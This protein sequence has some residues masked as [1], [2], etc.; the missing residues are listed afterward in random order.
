MKKRKRKRRSSGRYPWD[1]KRKKVAK[2]VV[3]S[4]EDY[5]TPKKNILDYLSENISPKNSLN[6]HGI[7]VATAAISKTPK[8]T[9]LHKYLI[10]TPKNKKDDNI[11]TDNKE[12]EKK[13]NINSNLE[14]IPSNNEG[15]SSPKRKK[16]AAAVSGSDFVVGCILSN[17][18][19]VKPPDNHNKHNKTVVNHQTSNKTLTCSNQA[20]KSSNEVSKNPFSNPVSSSPISFQTLNTA[21]DNN[22]TTNSSTN[23]FGSCSPPFENNGLL[24][25]QLEVGKMWETKRDRQNIPSSFSDAGRSFKSARHKSLTSSMFAYRDLP[26]RDADDNDASSSSSCSSNAEVSDDDL[27]SS[28]EFE[29]SEIES[30]DE[31]SPAVDPRDREVDSETFQRPVVLG[32]S[33]GGLKKEKFTPADD[34]AE[35]KLVP[36]LKINI[37]K[38]Q[39][40]Q[41][42]QVNKKKRG[43]PRKNPVSDPP[44]E[45]GDPSVVH[46]KKRGRK[47]KVI[48]EEIEVCDQTH[49]SI[50][51]APHGN[52]NESI[53]ESQV[54]DIPEEGFISQQDEDKQM[55]E[56]QDNPS[57]IDIPENDN[58]SYLEED[59]CL[60]IETLEKNDPNIES[61]LLEVAYVE[62]N[63]IVKMNAEVDDEQ[64]ENN[65]PSDDNNAK[66]NIP[67]VQENGMLLLICKIVYS[68]SL[69]L[70]VIP[71]QN[72]AK[73]SS[74]AS[75]P[76]AEFNNDAA[77]VESDAEAELDAANAWVEEKCRDE[78]EL[79]K[80]QTNLPQGK[81]N[82]F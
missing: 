54:L 72:I 77:R 60:S 53:P 79:E 47:K 65:I 6:N 62:N 40:V 43:R 3:K 19:H 13:E 24:N 57:I 33:F 18:G 14:S 7:V 70:V 21:F 76:P 1:P 26:R 41:N 66:S 37:N 46:R 55:E 69:I 67:L 2:K 68:D 10:K 61:N 52:H 28:S 58:D 73:S 82:Y 38:Q 20:Q 81:Y 23:H 48:Q 36:K 27:S 56:L 25:K 15:N 42:D 16:R 50:T 75:E 35:N 51:A 11:D 74:I 32:N 30:E 8:Q 44:N 29:S 34:S 39:V 31:S 71:D 80:Q 64:V 17:G 45:N 22:S 4:S 12:I 5:K 63:D 49:S 9:T 78:A 59:D